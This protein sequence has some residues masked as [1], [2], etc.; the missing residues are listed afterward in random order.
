M[1]TIEDAIQYLANEIWRF[2]ESKS[3]A[4]QCIVPSDYHTGEYGLVSD[5][6]V[7]ELKATHFD[8]AWDTRGK[9]VRLRFYQGDAF[10]AA[11][12]PKFLKSIVVLI[13]P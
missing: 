11:L 5:I 6:I 8:R 12:N 2:G 10:G 7:K 13:A 3:P 1:K 4:C 9:T